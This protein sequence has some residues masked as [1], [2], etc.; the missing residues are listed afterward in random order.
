MSS[1]ALFGMFDNTAQIYKITYKYLIRC[2]FR[3]EQ[4]LTLD[5]CHGR[6]FGDYLD[7]VLLVCHNFIYILI[8][9][10]CFIKVILR[11]DAVDYA[12]AVEHFYFLLER[13]GLDGSVRLMIL[14]AP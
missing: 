3:L 5:Y 11:T 1:D 6:K 8:C 13:K 14:P 2:I 7:K 4:V 12:L 9:A 10:G